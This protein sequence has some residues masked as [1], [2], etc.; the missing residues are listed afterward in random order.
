MHNNWDKR[1]ITL[2]KLTMCMGMWFDLVNIV[3]ELVPQNFED[4]LL[5]IHTICPA[6]ISMYTDAV[7]VGIELH[8]LPPYTYL[9]LSMIT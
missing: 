5:S 6:I 9:A 4:P 8:Y 3:V 2:I 7:P 1:T